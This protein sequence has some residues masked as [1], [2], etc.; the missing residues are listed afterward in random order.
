MI[1]QTEIFMLVTA[2]IS[3]LLWAGIC[4]LRILYQSREAKRHDQR[5]TCGETVVGFMISGIIGQIIYWLIAWQILNGIALGA[6]MLIQNKAQTIYET[7]VQYT[8]DSAHAGI[9]TVIG[10]STEIYHYDAD[11]LEAEI[12]R[13][14]PYE[15]PFWFAVTA[16][17]NGRVIGAYFTHHEISSNELHPVKTE[18]QKIVILHP[19]MGED[20]VIGSWTISDQ[21]RQEKMWGTDSTE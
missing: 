4:I 18:Q 9:R 8:E 19:Y 14:F 17:K 11:S 3:I 7:A 13:Q 6:V 21:K 2:V 10:N 15:R 12:I 5:Y 20:A 16:D 1:L